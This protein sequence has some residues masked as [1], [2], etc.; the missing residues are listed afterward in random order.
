MTLERWRDFKAELGRRTVTPFSHVT[1]SFYFFAS[2]LVVG[3]LGLWLEMI[4]LARG[5]GSPG[6]VRSALG[7]YA[8]GLFGSSA[9]HLFLGDAAKQLKAFGGSLFLLA[10][11]AA[12]WIIFDKRMDDGIAYL[13]GAASS[14]LGL[15]FWI[16][17][18]SDEPIFQD[19]DIRAATGG[20]N[21]TGP[22]DETGLDDFTV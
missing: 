10:G 12:G 1:M 17:V 22:L 3:G 16:I 2:I 21:P 8:F 11:I 4:S 7:T 9:L 5:D 20:D 19:A 15:W 6:N 14:A 18:N 13:V